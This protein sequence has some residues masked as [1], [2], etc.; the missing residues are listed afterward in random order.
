[1]APILVIVPGSFGTSDMYEP[2][3]EPLREKGYNIH[4][5]DPP[6]YPKGYKKGTPAPHMYADAKF[7]SDYVTGLADKDSDD[8]VMMAHSYGGKWFSPITCIKRD[9]CF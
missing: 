5:L 7:I 3:V 6:C 8:I 9:M 1:M 2:V 4:V